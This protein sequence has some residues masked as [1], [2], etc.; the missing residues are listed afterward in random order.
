MT[1]P[2]FNP[3]TNHV[4]Q[5]LCDLDLIPASQLAIESICSWRLQRDA[6]LEFKIFRDDESIRYSVYN[7]YSSAKRYWPSS[8]SSPTDFIPVFAHC[9]WKGAKGVI[10]SRLFSDGHMAVL[11]SVNPRTKKIGVKEWAGDYLSDFLITRN[12]VISAINDDASLDFQEEVREVPRTR[13]YDPE[14]EE[15]MIRY[16]RTPREELVALGGEPVTEETAKVW[17][18][19]RDVRLIRIAAGLREEITC[20]S[21]NWRN[22]QN[23]EVFCRLAP[24]SEADSQSVDAIIQCMQTYTPQ[25]ENIK[26]KELITFYREHPLKC[27]LSDCDLSTLEA[28]HIQKW[29]YNRLCGKNDGNSQC[30]GYT[31]FVNAKKT[32]FSFGKGDEEAG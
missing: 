21:F 29:V 19:D 31:N 25:L 30:F 24:G 13:F 7:H 8:A 4:N 16:R 15:G 1:I 9:V 32:A 26:N 27:F 20:R 18:A 3:S 22:N 12:P 23:P 5:T 2:N 17:P 14:A 6:T 28:T 11:L 10:Q